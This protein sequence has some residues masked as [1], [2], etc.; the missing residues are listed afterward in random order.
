MAKIKYT[1]REGGKWIELEAH[2]IQFPDGQEWDE[3]N[4]MRRRLNLPTIKTEIAKR[5]S[6]LKCD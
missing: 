2:S 1:T 6:K 3:T 4:G 5:R